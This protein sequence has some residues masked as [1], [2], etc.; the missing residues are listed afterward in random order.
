MH[1]VF[2]GLAIKS[3]IEF[4]K[5]KKNFTGISFNQILVNV[6]SEIL[7]TLYLIDS[8]KEMISSSFVWSRVW[9]I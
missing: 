2:Y 5:D 8:N 6:L 1:I 3:D 9:H 4:W 7:I